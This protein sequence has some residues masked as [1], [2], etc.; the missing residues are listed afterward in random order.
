MSPLNFDP[1]APALPISSPA[2]YAAELAKANG[3]YYTQGM[4]EN[5]GVLSAGVF[6]LGE[7]LA[8]ARIAG[9][10]VVDQFPYVMS[11]FDRGLLFYYEGNT[12]QISHMMWR[13]MDPGHPAYDPVKDPPFADAVPSAY[14]E[15]DRLVTYALDHAGDNTLVIAMS[16]HGFT[17]WRRTFHLNAWLH[18]NGY[19]AVHDESLPAGMELLTNVEWPRTRAY[20]F[21]LNALYVNLQGWEKDGIVPEHERDALL[22]ELKQRLEG[23]IDFATGKPAVGHV[24]LRD[25]TYSDAGQR[26]IGPDA[27][28]GWAKSTQNADSSTLGEMDREILTDNDK[29]WSGDHEM[30]PPSV[31]GILATS[32]TLKR[33]AR[34]L[35]ELNASVFAEF[36]VE[37]ERC[38]TPS[39]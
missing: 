36:G 5:T 26:A 24:Y 33:P 37:V 6:S 16:D 22:T 18:Q 12:D 11:R 28:M 31:P 7:F 29:P 34:N 19:L 23:T 39:P 35:R 32:R 38:S 20:G 15:A 10:E 17:S 1:L 14:E 27:V 30:D 8:Q 3:R 21:G 13:P 2:S 25:Q 4:P 9:K